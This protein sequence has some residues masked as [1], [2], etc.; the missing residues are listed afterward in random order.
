MS[1]VDIMIIILEDLQTLLKTLFNLQTEELLKNSFE[2]LTIVIEA[3]QSF[4]ITFVEY[5][6]VCGKYLDI[7]LR[8]AH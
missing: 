6:L 5:C 3:K 4:Y 8:Q 1:P 2:L 7:F